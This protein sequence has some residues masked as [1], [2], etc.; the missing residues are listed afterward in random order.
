MLKTKTLKEKA[1]KEATNLTK[2]VKRESKRPK[3]QKPS[4][5]QKRKCKNTQIEQDIREDIEEM[6]EDDS[7]S[8]G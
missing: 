4:A 3:T 6:V 1:E 8:T 2:R 7:S 5:G